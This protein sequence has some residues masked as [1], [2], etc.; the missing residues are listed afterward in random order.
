MKFRWQNQGGA[1][2]LTPS[3]AV[4]YEVAE[5]TVAPE[6]GIFWRIFVN[7]RP[8]LL[9]YT[10]EQGAKLDAWQFASSKRSLFGVYRMQL[11]A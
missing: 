8:M 7:S 10:S 6:D 1:W 3:P 2:H 5:I 4:K 11:A 9:R